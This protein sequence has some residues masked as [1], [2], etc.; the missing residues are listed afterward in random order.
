MLWLVC[1]Q[2]M[3]FNYKQLFDVWIL[4]N[5]MM[6]L[7]SWSVAISVSLWIQ[8]LCLQTCC[9]QLHQIHTWHTTDLSVKWVR[10]RR[11]TATSPS[12]RLSM[13]GSR[14]R[15]VTGDTVTR[16]CAEPSRRYGTAWR[17][18]LLITNRT[19]SKVDTKDQFVEQVS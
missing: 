1:V 11:L 9:F 4:H 18:A 17:S 10:V 3:F 12:G 5:A 14:Q 16:R 15:S 6:H 8:Y 2:N 7:Y 19:S 13:G